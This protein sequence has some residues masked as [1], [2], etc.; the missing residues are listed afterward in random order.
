MDVTP[1]I[2]KGQQIIQSYA[3]GAFKISGVVYNGPVIVLPDRVIAWA[4]APTDIAALTPAHF[5]DLNRSEFDVL[6]IGCGKSMT[7]LPA[8]S[9]KL[10]KDSGLSPDIMDT[11][12]ACRT[13]NVLVAEGRRTAAAL[14]PS[15]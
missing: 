11:G 9:R 3:G 12:A 15:L 4:G 1:L 8:A 6:L 7:I 13:W 14:L 2:R 10:L 5:A